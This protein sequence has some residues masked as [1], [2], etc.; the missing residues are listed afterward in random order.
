MLPSVERF[1]AQAARAGMDTTD[2]YAFGPDYAETL[3]RWDRACVTQR[4]QIDGLGFDEHFMRIWH[5]Y[6]AYCEAAFDEGRTDV[7]QFVLQKR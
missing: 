7:V 5:L 2:Q 1:V 3:R 4:Q 6:F